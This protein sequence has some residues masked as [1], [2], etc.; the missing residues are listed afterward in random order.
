M[1]ANGA[2][3]CRPGAEAAPATT[4]MQRSGAPSVD[5]PRHGGRLLPH[6]DIDADHVAGF[7]VDHG[8]D[9]DRGLADRTVANDQFALAAAQR[10]QRIDGHDAGLHRLG[11]QRAVEDRRGRPLHRIMAFGNDRRP[12][13]QRP[14]QRIDH[15][16]EQARAD[17]GAH[18]LAGAAHDL[19]RFQAADLVQQHAADQL[20]VE[21][22]REAKLAGAEAQDLVQPRIRQARHHGD[23]VADAGDMADLGDLRRQRRGGD[24]ALRGFKPRA[25]G[26]HG[27]C[28]RAEHG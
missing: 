16:P 1:P 28:L 21:R 15:P 20:G 19:A 26:G 18:H 4:K 27:R 17:R 9:G 12:T 7:L 6:R 14:A 24:A 8:I 23:A 10:K 2:I 11:D 22:L 25:G 3:H 5:H 13:V